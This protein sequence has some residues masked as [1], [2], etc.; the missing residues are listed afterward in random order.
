MCRLSPSYH[1]IYL[2]RARS[3]LDSIKPTAINLHGIFWTCRYRLGHLRRKRDLRGRPRRHKRDFRR[4]RESLWDG[5][6]HRRRQRRLVGALH[7]LELPHFPAMFV[8]FFT[9]ASFA[10]VEI[11]Q[12]TA[13]DEDEDCFFRR[14]TRDGGS[15]R[16]NESAR[17]SD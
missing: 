13:D 10:E 6:L 15:K 17:D 9:L 1:T 3:K 14:D 8:T 2:L 5:L 16:Y 11:R 4:R 12:E 7:V